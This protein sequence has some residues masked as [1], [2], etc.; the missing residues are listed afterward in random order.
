MACDKNAVPLSSANTKENAFAGFS[1][2]LSQETLDKAT[3][4]LFALDASSQANA[5]LVDEGDNSEKRNNSL[6]K[7]GSRISSVQLVPITGYAGRVTV[8]VK[9]TPHSGATKHFLISVTFEKQE[10]QGAA[11]QNDTD[12]Q[13]ALTQDWVQP[14]A[15]SVSVSREL[16]VTGHRVALQ[17]S[18]GAPPQ[19]GEPVQSVDI[20]IKGE[21]GTLN[22]KP[23]PQTL[24]GLD[25]H[26]AGDLASM[27]V[28][29][30][31]VPVP[32]TLT[33]S[34]VVHYQ[35]GIA[36]NSQPVNLSATAS[37]AILFWVQQLPRWLRIIFVVGGLAVLGFAAIGIWSRPMAF[38]RRK[39]PLEQFLE[40]LGFG[41]SVA[42]LQSMIEAEF[43][44][45]H[46]RLDALEN[47]RNGLTGQREAQPP[48]P[49]S[50]WTKT[51]DFHSPRPNLSVSPQALPQST[52]AQIFEQLV[53]R[54]TG[55]L[56]DLTLADR[57]TQDFSVRGASPSASGDGLVLNT[58]VRD[59]PL[60]AIPLSAEEEAQ[61]WAVLPGRASIKNWTHFLAP[62]GGSG[63]LEQLGVAFQLERDASGELRLLQSAMATFDRQRKC[64]VVSQ[65]GR[66]SGIS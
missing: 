48:V 41:T 16:D 3:T 49:Y 46:A 50:S 21:N 51:N 63:A 1:G 20:T 31:E 58:S 35:D 45:V 57:F 33:V 9:E 38:V 24:A 62:M 39:E 66:L 64:L 53:T 52:A 14:G 4:Y 18:V 19:P 11:A 13:S 15:P 26:Q 23:L 56:K 17:I 34:A 27:V 44:S 54:Y 47:A 43:R 42:G 59:A 29:P 22:G 6:S 32:A 55:V 37:E 2:A 36:T 10:G 8:C 5:A 40:P 7:T 28:F 61:S 25:E 30:D 60:W 65:K 12:T